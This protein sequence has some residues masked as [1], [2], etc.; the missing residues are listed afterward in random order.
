[1]RHLIVIIITL[2]IQPIYIKGDN[3]QLYKQLDAALAQRAHYVELK[4]KSLNEIKQGAKYVTSNEDKLKL[5][6]QLANE[7]KAYEYDS[8][9]TYVNKGLILAQKSNNIFFNK[10]FQLSQTRLLI[11]R[12]FY[13]EA[14]EILQKIEPKEEPR[15]YQFLYYYTMYGLYNNWST[16]CENNEFSKNYDLKKVEYLKKAI[17]LSPK[18]DAFYYYLMGELYYFSNHPNNNKTIQYYKKA[19]NMEKTNSRLHAMTAFALS[20]VY[21]KA[22][23]LELMEHYLLVAAISDITSATKENVALQDIALFIYKHKTRSLNK[24]Q[25]YINLSLED[26]YTYKSR[27]RRIEIS[28]KLQLITN[29]YTDDIK[30]TNRLLNIALLVIILLLLGVGISSL[31]IRK[32]N[33]LLKQKKDEISA[34]SDKME[35]LNGQLHLIN[36]ELKDTNQKRERLV[37]VYIDLCYKNI[38]RNQKLRTLAVRK[39]KANQSKELLS[40]L[41]SSSSTEKENKEFLTEFDKAFLSLYPT[42]VNELNQQLTESAHI[43]LKEN[44]EMPPILRVCALLRLGITESSKIAGILSYSPQTVYN[45]RSILKNNAI[46]K[47]HFEENVLKLCMII[48]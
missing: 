34:T 7:Y 33:R 25:E 27:L 19:L 5:Y 37:K 13:A 44:G 40:L 8:A 28:S 2:M 39:I 26:A 14:K 45:Y 16:Y 42:F 10:R 20:E 38:E 29:A 15:D 22:N 31:F 21:Q 32:K 23:N 48:A 11:T 41:S 4:E 3:N 30:T 35:K 6:E 1:M 46:D 12:G 24:A 47:E 36:D 43:Q 17:E 18:K 9:M